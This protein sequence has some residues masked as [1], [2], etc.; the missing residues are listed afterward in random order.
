[1][2]AIKRCHHQNGRL[3]VRSFRGV[4]SG[5]TE[6]TKSRGPEGPWGP[7]KLNPNIPL[8]WGPLTVPCSWPPRV[9]LHSCA[10]FV[11]YRSTR[12]V[13]INACASISTGARCSSVVRAF[14]HGAMGRWIDPSW[15]GPIE[16]FLVP[17]SAPRL[18]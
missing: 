12:C 1:M 9:L 2:E 18:M 13:S 17:A 8:V 6:W 16:L 15:G 4:V 3:I 11:R 14:A 7:T 10:Q 5:W